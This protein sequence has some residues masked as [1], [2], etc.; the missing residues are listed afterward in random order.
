MRNNSLGIT[1]A[2]YFEICE[3]TKSKPD[4]AKIPID[5]QDFLL[6]TQIAMEIVHMLPDKWDGTNGRYQ[7]KDMSI[8][9]FLLDLHSIGD[10]AAM[11]VLILDIIRESSDI[12]NEEVAKRMKHGR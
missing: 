3:V 2:N 11:M 4:P 6:D 1:R 8:L 10:K 7:G 5:F 9:P 12:T